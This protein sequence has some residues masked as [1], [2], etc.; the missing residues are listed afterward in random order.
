[1]NSLSN[2]ICNH[3]KQAD[4][5]DF[6]TCR[7]CGQK[8]GTTPPPP[9]KTY[10]TEKALAVSAA[11]IVMFGVVHHDRAVYDKQ[12]ATTLASVRREVSASHRPRVLEFGADWCGACRAYGPTIDGA[13]SRYPQIDFIRYN[14][15]DPKVG[16]LVDGLGVRAIPVTCFFDR[17]GKLINQEVGAL[18]DDML[19]DRLKAIL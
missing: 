7:Y 12:R 13:K 16:D 1:M 18:P 15:E 10:L 2:K 9:P 19:D 6:S 11:A 14:I 17:D 4:I 3:C 8:Y 5:T